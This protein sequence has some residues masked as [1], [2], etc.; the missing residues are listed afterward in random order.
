MGRRTRKENKMRKIA[1]LVAVV[2]RIVSWPLSCIFNSVL[3]YNSPF[4]KLVR[5]LNIYYFEHAI[6]L[7]LYIPNILSLRPYLRSSARS[8][9]FRGR[10]EIWPVGNRLSINLGR[11]VELYKGVKIQGNGSLSIGDNSIITSNVYLGIMGKIE[12][13][14]NVMIADNVSMRTDE[15]CHARTDI[16][17]LG[18]GGT[19]GNI[20]IEDDVWIAYGAV[21]TKGVRIGKGSI[22][23]ANAVVT[24]DVPP[25]SIVG[26]VPAKI[27]T[28]RKEGQT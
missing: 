9:V 5:L 28:S 21:I 16:P 10:I 12:I 23:A 8:L 1:V 11:N 20:T 17:M 15:H 25:Y 14:S 22:V 3:S 13:G 24:K 19:S 7:V 18:Q 6:P 2:I 26:G 4:S 27:I